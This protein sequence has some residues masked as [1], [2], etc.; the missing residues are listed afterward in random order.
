[1]FENN[2]PLADYHV[3]PD[4]SFDAEGSID[5]YCR[6]AVEK[7]ISEICFTTHY[8][9]NPIL[10]EK[11]RSIKLNGRLVLNSVENIKGYVDAVRAAREKYFLP[12]VK[13]GIEIGYYPGCEEQ[14][15]QLFSKYSFDYRLGAIHEVGDFD[16]CSKKHFERNHA[17]V[18]IEDLADNYFALVRQAVET[19]LFDAIA[20]L[21]VYKKYGLQYYGDPLL[22]V[23][24]GRVESVFEAMVRTETGLEINTSALRKGH[25]EYYPSMDLVNAARK[26]GVRIVAIGSDAHRPEELGYDFETAIAIAYELIP[27]YNE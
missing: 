23:H 6:A 14:I 3:H 19:G 26:K 18:K 8:D 7:G 2:Y 11:A 27:Y 13:C 24:R 4:F 10:S 22:T 12:V 5:E 9:T 15:S 16:V 20:H 25:K 17:N 21:D 1:M